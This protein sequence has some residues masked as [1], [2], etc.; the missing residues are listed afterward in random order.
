ML[1]EGLM[2]THFLVKRKRSERGNLSPKYNSYKNTFI[3]AAAFRIPELGVQLERGHEATHSL[4]FC[5]KNQAQREKNT[6]VALYRSLYRS[7]PCSTKRS[8]PKNEKG[9][10]IFGGYPQKTFEENQ[11]KYFFSSKCTRNKIDNQN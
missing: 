7:P 6:G 11:A 4:F 5:E 9:G 3:F 1:I 2:M 10:F 8:D